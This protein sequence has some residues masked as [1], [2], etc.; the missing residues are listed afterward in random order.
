MTHFTTIFHTRVGSNVTILTLAVS[1]IKKNNF[2]KNLGVFP[3]ENMNLQK[4]LGAVYF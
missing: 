1:Q 3:N 2:Q 4:S